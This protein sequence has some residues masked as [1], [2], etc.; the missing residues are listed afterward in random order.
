MSDK[1]Y[2]VTL[3][4]STCSDQPWCIP[5]CNEQKCTYLCQHMVHCSCMDY[6]QGHLCKH[7]HKVYMYIHRAVYYITIWLFKTQ[8]RIKHKKTS[9]LCITKSE[10]HDEEK[11]YTT[12]TTKT[13]QTGVNVV[14][15]AGARSPGLPR[16]SSLRSPRPSCS[17][18]ATTGTAHDIS[19]YIHIFLCLHNI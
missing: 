6:A 19:S 4:A 13:V 5:Q 12:N 3:R 16:R 14:R 8:V 15:W 7:T 11:N 2:T 9:T 17:M 10:K 1:V 18:Y